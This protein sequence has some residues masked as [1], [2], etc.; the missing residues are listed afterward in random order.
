MAE[1]SR[2]CGTKRL[3]RVFALAC[4]SA[5]AWSFRPPRR[6]GYGCG[7]ADLP[8]PAGMSECAFKNPAGK[9][10]AAMARY[11]ATKCFIRLLAGLCLGV[12]LFSVNAAAH[13]AARPEKDYAR[14]SASD[15]KLFFDGKE[16]ENARIGWVHGYEPAQADSFAPGALALWSAVEREGN[17]PEDPNKWAVLFFTKDGKFTSSIPVEI[18]ADCQDAYVSSGGEYVLLMGG[19][20]MRAEVSYTVY[21]FSDGKPQAAFPGLRNGVA[22]VDSHRFVVT[23]IQWDDTRYPLPLASQPLLVSFSIVLHDA[24]ANQTTPLMPATATKDFMLAEEVKGGASIVVSE[25]S[26]Q[27]VKDWKDESKIQTRELTVAIPDA[28]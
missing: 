15:D 28:K 17:T 10:R 3:C 5:F 13:A 27:H 23:T 22:W 14:Y 26:V 7:V 12:F 16:V 6:A 1:R 25:R 2:I 9:V 20:P 21:A 8:Y 4:G 18:E 24:S 11:T 19:S